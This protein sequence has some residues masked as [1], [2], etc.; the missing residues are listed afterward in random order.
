MPTYRVDA[1]KGFNFSLADDA[2]VCQKKNHFQVTVYVGMLGDAKYIKTSEGLQP[3]DCFYLKLHGVKVCEEHINLNESRRLV[4]VFTVKRL[5]LPGGGDKSVNQC[6]AVPV[7]PQQ[8]TI[9][10]RTV[11]ISAYFYHHYW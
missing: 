8:E 3:I 2:F 7:W 1:D 6:G 4:P 10:A 9:Q 11:S 5:L